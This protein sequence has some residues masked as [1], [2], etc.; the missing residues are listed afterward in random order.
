MFNDAFPYRLWC[1]PANGTPIYYA[2]FINGTGELRQ[3]E[4]SRDIYLAMRSMYESER[5]LRRSDERHLERSALSE[6]SLYRRA[7]IRPKSLEQCF[8]EQEVTELLWETINE[9]PEPQRGRLLLYAVGQ[10]T[11]KQIADIYGCAWQAVQQSV[12]EARK[13]I[14][15]KLFE[16]AL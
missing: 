1:D 3:I 12:Y 16:L 4:I 5:N 9:L 7:F 15:H 13:K 14:L 8:V 6:Q 2:I 11:Y 10:L